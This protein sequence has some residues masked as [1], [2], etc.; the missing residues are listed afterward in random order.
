MAEEVEGT[1]VVE[2]PKYV[3]R[4]RSAIVRSPM[5]ERDEVLGFRESLFGAADPDHVAWIY[6]RAP[7][8]PEHGRALWTWRSGGEIKAHQGAI[9]TT[10]HVLDSAR[11]LSWAID[12]M[13]DA[14]HRVR[15]VGAVMPMVVGDEAEIV[16][17]TE[18][19]LAAQ[20]AFSRAGWTSLGTVPFW[21]R[22]LDSYQ[23]LQTRGRDILRVTGAV[24]DVALGAL[25]R[26]TKVLD[27]NRRLVPGERF[28]QRADE[29][30]AASAHEWPVIARRDLEWLAWRWD[31][32][33]DFETRLVWLEKRGETI[34]W[35]VLAERDHNGLLGGF[36]LDL[37]CRRADLGSLV[38]LAVRELDDRGCDA[39]YCMF[40]APDTR[41]TFRSAGFVQR[42]TQMAMMVDARKLPTDERDAVSDPAR[43][44]LTAGDSDLDR[45]R[46][47]LVDGQR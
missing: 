1:R 34:G 44:Y 41:R 18:V 3:E 19:S 32:N 27:R 22:P 37:L 21:V 46:V 31:D 17:G 36:V 11:S 9:R 12:L 15:G 4:I 2:Q 42:D 26:V 29:I 35:A 30:W 16:A 23:L 28:D 6:D 47:P 43:W 13:V 33:P 7:G 24:M 25:Q 14:A 40:Q 38:R 39:V 5:S 10:L 45:V 8:V 20:K